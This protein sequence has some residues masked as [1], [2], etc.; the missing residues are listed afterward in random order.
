MDGLKSVLQEKSD[1]MQ[2]LLDDAA[3]LAVNKP[4]GLLTQAPPGIESLEF[5]VKRLLAARKE[6]AEGRPVAPETVYLGVPHRLDRPVSGAIVFALDRKSARILARQFEHRHVRKLY[7]ACVEGTVDPREGT[8]VDQI[9][10]V[11]NQAQAEIVLADHPEGRPGILHYR[12]IGTTRFGAWLQIELETG[13]MHQVRVQ[14]AARGCPVLG[15]AQYGSRVAFGPQHEDARL[16]AIALHARFISFRH[17]RTRQQME[18]TAEPPPA[19]H[20]LNLLRTDGEGTEGA[21]GA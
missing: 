4:P 16:R 8:W 6:Q 17:P 5:D 3:L 9:R 12:V 11:P 21:R 18:L 15:D 13:R 20:D 1:P 14:A 7:W 2:I 19:W 10:K